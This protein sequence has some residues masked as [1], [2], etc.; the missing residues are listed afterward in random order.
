[1]PTRSDAAPTSD[2]RQKVSLVASCHLPI[3]NRLS[4]PNTATLVDGAK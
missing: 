2:E 4:P 3:V 1:M